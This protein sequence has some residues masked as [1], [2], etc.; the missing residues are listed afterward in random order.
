MWLRKD[1]TEPSAKPVLIGADVVLRAP[2]FSDYAQWAEVRGR[3]RNYLKPYEP[4]WPAGCLAPDFFKRRIERL[5]HERAK[6]QTHAFLICTKED[7]LIGGINI[8]NVTRGAGQMGSLGYWIDEAQQ[9][10][11]FMAQSCRLVL[12]YAFSTLG[13]AR[14]NAATLV[15][16]EKSRTML[17]RLGFTEEGFA[18][19]YIQIDGR[20]QDHVLYGLNAADFLRAS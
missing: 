17:L 1:K 7:V 15:H 12:D 3:N 19:T 8:N 18:K 5:D 13:L 11:G 14:M 4:T 20:R 9:G 16:N 10:K 2:E 6:D